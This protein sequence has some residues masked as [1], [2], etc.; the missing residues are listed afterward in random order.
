M[1]IVVDA[2]A[3]IISADEL[4]SYLRD[5]SLTDDSS[6]VFIADLAE[7]L[8]RDLTGDV[9]TLPIRVKAI[10]LEVAAR[11]WR[12][13]NGYSSETVDD[14]TY[15]RDPNT[16]Q[17]GVYLTDDERGEI[18]QLVGMTGGSAYSVGVPSPIDVP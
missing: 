2:T 5:P 9:T 14:Y 11:A 7:T 13:P 6:F 1:P 8:V 10:T 17:A 12:N 18:L 3:G 15:R 4:A 16:R